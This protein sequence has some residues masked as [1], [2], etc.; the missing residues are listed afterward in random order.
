MEGQGRQARHVLHLLVDVRA[1]PRLALVPLRGDGR[2]L[3][4]GPRYGLDGVRRPELEG[5]RQPR[6]RLH[7]V[8][9]LRQRE[10]AAED[11]QV[12]RAPPRDGRLPLEALQPGPRGHQE[13]GG[14]QRQQ[15]LPRDP[16]QHDEPRD[17][18]VGGEERGTGNGG[19][20]SASTT[21]R[22]PTRRRRWRTTSAP[23]AART[24]C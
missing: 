15:E 14:D 20:R 4:Q 24:T 13:L 12:R 9:F 19:T 2:R 1:L 3:L 5:L 23:P 17:P 8:L 11:R 16:G 6:R 22:A 18:R 7:H 10:K 21:S